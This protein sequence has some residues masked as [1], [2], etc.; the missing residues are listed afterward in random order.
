MLGR[1][2]SPHPSAFERDYEHRPVCPGPLHVNHCLWEFARTHRAR[3]SICTQD[4]LPNINFNNQ[5]HIF[6]DTAQQQ[7]VRFQNEMYAY[8]DVLS[9]HSIQNKICMTP[10]F[11]DDTIEPSHVWIQ[12][13]TLI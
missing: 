12:T 3:R 11:R 6:G 5:K 1:W 8:Y 9:P 13:V 7:R 2:F 4:G 10:E